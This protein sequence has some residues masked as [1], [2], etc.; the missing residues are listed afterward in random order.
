MICSS[1]RFVYL[2]NKHMGKPQGSKKGIGNVREVVKHDFVAFKRNRMRNSVT[3]NHSFY[4]C[5]RHVGI[6]MSL[7][8]IFFFC[9]FCISLIL[10]NCCHFDCSLQLFTEYG[11]LAMDEI[12]LK[13]FQ[14]REP[15]TFIC[16]LLLMLDINVIFTFCFAVMKVIVA[17]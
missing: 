4:H 10:H 14:V 15:W 16:P 8:L 9:L 2:R 7:F 1:Y 13:P 6:F 17:F 5:L 3:L 12:F 11:R